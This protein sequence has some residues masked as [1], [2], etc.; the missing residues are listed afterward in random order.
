[1]S[2]PT[3]FRCANCTCS[4]GLIS[5]S[6]RSL[7]FFKQINISRLNNSSYNDSLSFNS[8]KSGLISNFAYCQLESKKINTTA[9]LQELRKEMKKLSLGVYI[10][11]SEDQHH[12]EYV[13]LVDQRVGFMTG[14]SGSA[15]VAIV[16][17][18]LNCLNDELDGLAAFSTDGRYIL[19]AQNEL[20]FNWKILTQD[21]SFHQ[22]WMKWSIEQ[23]EAISLESDIVVKVGFDPKLISYKQIEKIS[24][25]LK[26]KLDK[27]N[28]LNIEVVS[29][30]ENL[31]DKIWNRFEVKPNITFNE[32]KLYDLNN[33]GK[34]VYEKIN[35]VKQNLNDKFEGII[36]FSLDEIAWLLNLRGLDI[37][38]NPVFYSFIILTKNYG[39]FFFVKVEKLNQKILELLTLN[40]IEIK[41]Y[42][43]FYSEL[44]LLTKKITTKKMLVPSNSNWEIIKSMNCDYE[45]DISIVETLKSIK[46]KFEIKNAKISHIKD[47]KALV[48]FFSWLEKQINNQSIIDEYTACEKLLEFKKEEENFVDISFATISAS[49]PNSSI[50]HYQPNKMHSSII[51]PYKIYLNDS[52]SHFLEGTTDVTRTLHFGSPTEEE[53]ENYT[54]VLKSN[55]ALGSLKFPQNVNGSAIDSIA[56]QHLWKNGLDYNH[57]T[58]HGVGCFLNVHEG[59][60]NILHR[61]YSKHNVIKAGQII[62]NEPGYYKNN[63]YGIRIE[64]VMVVKESKLEFNNENFLEFETLTRV[65]YCR[66]LINTKIL[67]KEE[68]ILINSYHTLVWNE[69]NLFFQPN[70]DEYKWLKRETKQ[71]VL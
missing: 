59:S 54:L 25:L 23:A 15:G 49:G 35:E 60:I 31:I 16:T 17:C 50:I 66:K 40:G 58:S 9:R 8:S 62:S 51:N 57:G 33:C 5:K 37:T 30:N 44:G 64:N 43:L 68:I 55:L 21:S 42:E 24:S 61:S 12:S 6:K 34:L 46:N 1:M 71:I 3:R 29:V 14:F 52:G 38:Y 36:L 39:I 53:I 10:I 70:S 45:Q 4:P 20:D 67:T 22:S 63:E 11:P 13:S 18:N 56:R 48:K 32:I 19:Q 47:G 65:P 27:N 7:L 26:N 28:S 41:P 69:L 2:K